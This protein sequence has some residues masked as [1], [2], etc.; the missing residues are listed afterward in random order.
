MATKKIENWEVNDAMH[1]LKKAEEIR[2]NSVLMGQ[3]KRSIADLSKM[4]SGGPV[5]KTTKRK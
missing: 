5:K 4:V 2:K 1:T 3:V